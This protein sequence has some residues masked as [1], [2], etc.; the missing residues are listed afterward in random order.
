M[1]PAI[2]TRPAERSHGTGSK[3]LQPLLQGPRRGE[4]ERGR[5]T[6]SILKKTL[7]A[8]SLRIRPKFGKAAAVEI[9]LYMDVPDQLKIKDQQ[10]GASLF[11]IIISSLPFARTRR[12]LVCRLRVG[13]LL[14]VASPGQLKASPE[15][16]PD[17]LPTVVTEYP[18][19]S[20]VWILG[21]HGGQ[22][23]AIWA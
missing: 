22:L 7:Y 4:R 20:A 12:L 9:M 10:Q 15:T 2:S 21:L 5:Q 16:V 14:A 1:A 23:Q 13:M 18:I 6:D 8:L 3:E 17:L 19:P 11:D